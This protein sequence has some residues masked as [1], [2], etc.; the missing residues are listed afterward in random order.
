MTA[1]YFGITFNRDDTDARPTI[2]SDMSVIGLIGTAPAADADDFPLDTP[3]SMYSSDAA[4]LT[5]LGATGTLPAAL[6]GINAQ[7]AP[8]EVSARVVVVRVAAGIDD[9][10][11]ITNIVGVEGDQTGLFAFLRAGNLLA[12]IPRLIGAPGY[13]HQHES[14]PAETVVTRA[15]KAGG[16]TGG[17]TLTLASPAYGASVEAGV[18]QVRC[19]GGTYAGVGALRAGAGGDGSIAMASPSTGVGAVEGVYTATCII[20]ASNGGTFLIEDPNGVTIGAVAVGE[21]YDGQIKFTIS[22]GSAD[23]E[24]GDVFEITVSPAVPANG[25][26]FSVRRPG[27]AY[28]ANA[29]VGTP[30]D[31]AHIKFTLADVGAD[32]IVGDGFDVTVAISAGEALANPVCAALPGI[33][34]RLLADAIVEGPGNDPAVTDEAIQA[35]RETMNSE[36]LIAIDAWVKVG[37]GATVTPGVGYILGLAAANDYANGGVPSKSFANLPVQGIVGWARPVDFSLTDG[38]SQGQT[39]LSLGIGIGVRGQMGVESAAANSGYVFIGTE[40]TGDDTLWKFYS[41]SRMRDYIHLGLL[42]TLRTRL[43]RSNINLRSIDLVLDDVRFWLRDL[44]ADERILRDFRVSFEPSRN[45]PED[46]RLGK[47]RLYFAAEEAPPL[48]RLDIDS[49]RYR[50]ALDRLLVDLLA[51]VPPDQ[52]AA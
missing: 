29:V 3:V 42:R 52:V 18:Y 33:C 8:Y 24:I 34:N 10:A 48:V 2:G 5:A 51:S 46:L 30:Y 23:F 35:W 13:T 19:I 38:D 40:N 36:R 32:F 17:G 14:E 22:D 15:A 41:Q 49:R 44:A 50:P 6:I 12:V 43:G 31:T 21:A 26:T 37:A 28:L 45:S 7:L 47:F 16:N 27:G 4:M 39:L 1:P 9:D 11:T 25:G 20:E